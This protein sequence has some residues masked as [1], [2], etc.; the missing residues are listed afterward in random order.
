MAI[1]PDQAAA[2]PENVDEVV[3]GDVIEC[4][5]DKLPGLNV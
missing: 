4:H 2:T 5:I 3:V 1:L